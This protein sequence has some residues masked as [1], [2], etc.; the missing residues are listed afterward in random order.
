MFGQKFDF[1][2]PVVEIAFKV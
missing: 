1:V 2:Q